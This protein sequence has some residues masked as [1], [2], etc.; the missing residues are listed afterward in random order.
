MLLSIWV[1]SNLFNFCASHFSVLL[2]D[3]QL[4]L[5]FNNWLRIF[6][7]S[8][9]FE[10]VL[11]LT[12]L[13]VFEYGLC[14]YFKPMT[15]TIVRR[16]LSQQF[17]W[18]MLISLLSVS[19]HHGQAKYSDR[20]TFLDGSRSDPGNWIQLCSRH[21]VIGNNSHRNGW[22]KASICWYPSNEGKEMDRKPVGWSV[23]GDNEKLS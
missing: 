18:L 13:I 3:W 4:F 20:N 14:M 1:I 16:T 10:F 12:Y 11:W 22:R 9:S 15:V 5:C 19:G 6:Y 21:L 8:M 23:T 17:Q 7:V 2:T